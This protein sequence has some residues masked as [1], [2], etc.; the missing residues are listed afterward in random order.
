MDDT[1]FITI[2][3]II[4]AGSILGYASYLDFKTRRVSNRFWIVLS[5]IAIAILSLRMVIEEVR[6]EYLLI[7]VPILAILADVY[8]DFRD[9]SPL[10][11]FAPLLEYGCAIASTIILAYMWRDDEYF[12]HLMTIPVM[13][14][15]II[16]MYAFDI[17]RGGADAKALIALSIM[18][19]FYPQID[20]F[21]IIALGDWYTEV[22]FPFSFIVLVNA[23]ILVAF[24]PILFIVKNIASREFEI[25]YAFLGYKMDADEIRGKH[26]WLMEHIV[27][28][29]HV[30]HTKPR[31]KEELES[32]VEQLVAAGH[33]RLWITPKVPFIIPIFASLVFTTI[34]GNILLPI[35][36]L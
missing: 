31:R 9:D 13:M 15:A 24:L 20:V 23:A 16:V 28:G 10:A 5:V 30:R 29:N 7:L 36:N 2:I 22:F 33:G 26:V 4:T 14:F 8:I 34:V 25:P 12:L 6:L 19:P 27:D 11:G 18:F 1:T 35:M 3:Q 32:E 17:I 21:P